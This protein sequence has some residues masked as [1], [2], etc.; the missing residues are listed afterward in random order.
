MRQKYEF[1][2]L[3]IN[4][5]RVLAKFTLRGPFAHAFIHRLGI[6]HVEDEGGMTW[7]P[8]V[9]SYRRIK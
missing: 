5:E 8:L 2:F 4:T 7:H 1:T 9:I 6:T 3:N